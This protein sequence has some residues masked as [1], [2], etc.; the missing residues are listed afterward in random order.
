M[1]G[2]IVS[3]GSLCPGTGEDE[4]SLV[5]GYIEVTQCFHFYDRDG[6][7][8]LKPDEFREALQVPPRDGH[9]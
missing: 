9:E 6:D 8:R 2:F 1:T 5:P 4:V 3:R 7:G